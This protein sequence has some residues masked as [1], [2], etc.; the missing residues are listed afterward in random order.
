MVS[1][2]FPMFTRMGVLGIVTTANKTTDETGPEMNP[3][4]A[5]LETPVTAS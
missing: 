5:Y 3:C 2:S 4:V 1:V